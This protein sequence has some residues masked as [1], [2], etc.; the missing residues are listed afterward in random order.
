MIPK[1]LAANHLAGAQIADPTPAWSTQLREAIRDPLELCQQLGLN[2][3]ALPGGRAGLQG[4]DGLFKTL[5]PRPFLDRMQP[6]NSTDPLLLQVLPQGAESLQV[7]GFV[8]DPLE[9]AR[10]NPLPGLIHKYT[11]R[12]LLTLSGGCAVNCRYCFRRHFPYAENSLSR[13][14]LSAV[15]D[16]LNQ[17]P[18]VNEVILSGGD[19]LATPDARLLEV[20]QQLELQPSIKRLRIHTRL[21]VV[22]PARITPALLE[23]LNTSRLQTL[24]VMHINHPQEIDQAVSQALE[25]L[26]QAGVIL[27]NQSV[28]LRGVNDRAEV[29][30]EL[31]EKLFT[32][33]VLPY[34]LHTLDPVEGAAHFAMDASQHQ[35][36]Y[37]DLLARLPGYLVPR[38]VKEE[39]DR[40]SKTP[41]G[42]PVQQEMTL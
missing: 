11:S 13:P 21:P 26:K 9:E 17:H 38:L 30:A 33:G 41:L 5:V 23:G 8:T 29:L 32:N 39:A 22:V 24:M 6:G 36:L 20:I 12:V 27:L 34:Y 3:D 2:P 4:A 18:E 37:A 31:S 14:A 25:Q 1:T 7:P 42:W 40:P 19:P 10:F 35:T 15:L 16:Y 28:L